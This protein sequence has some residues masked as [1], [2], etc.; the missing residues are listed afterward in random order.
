MRNKNRPKA[1]KVTFVKGMNLEEEMNQDKEL[2]EERN[3]IEEEN[4]RAIVSWPY[5]ILGEDPTIEGSEEHLCLYAPAGGRA[6]A[7]SLGLYRHRP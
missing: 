2:R 7:G 5:Y 6:A 3:E 4:T 1:T